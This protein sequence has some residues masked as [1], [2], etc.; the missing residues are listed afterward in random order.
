MFSILN[1]FDEIRL[2]LRIGM[3]KNRSNYIFCIII[4]M[5]RLSYKQLWPIEPLNSHETFKLLGSHASILEKIKANE[6]G[7]HFQFYLS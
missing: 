7:C 4:T 5:K 3:K 1:Y 2:R 6:Y